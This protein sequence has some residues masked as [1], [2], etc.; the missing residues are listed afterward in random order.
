MVNNII[1]ETHNLSEAL[2]EKLEQAWAQTAFALECILKHKVAHWASQLHF[3]SEYNNVE[4]THDQI[5]EINKFYNNLL[6]EEDFS[7]LVR[8][9]LQQAWVKY[10]SD[11]ESIIN[12]KILC[13]NKKATFTSSY[14][15]TFFASNEF[16]EIEE[17]YFI[18]SKLSQEEV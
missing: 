13:P 10:L 8:K 2:Q 9:K 4:F 5:S 7:K 18:I 11:L 16:D 17:F 14:N 6:K 3:T 12:N 15:N 1:I